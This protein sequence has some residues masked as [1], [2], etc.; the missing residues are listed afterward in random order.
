MILI[1][2]TSPLNYLAQIDHFDIVER[3]YGHVIIPEAVYREL[4]ALQTPHKVRTLLLGKPEW[5]EVRLLAGPLDPTL[6]NLGPGE[7]QAIQLA[8]QLRADAIL[9]EDKQWRAE[10]KGSNL[11]R[12]T[13]LSLTSTHIFNPFSIGLKRPR[14]LGPFGS[15]GLHRLFDD[16]AERLVPSHSFCKHSPQRRNLAVH[17]VVHANNLLVRMHPVQTPDVLLERTFPG[18]WPGEKQRV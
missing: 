13:N 1:A 4:T 10:A 9:I 2:D 14:S 16:I 12:C 6:Q 11:L 8:E 5:L 15:G 7:Q 17:V 3:L 18:D